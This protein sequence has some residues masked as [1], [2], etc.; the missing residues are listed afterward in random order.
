[1]QLAC[2][3]TSARG[4]CYVFLPA[5]AP[6]SSQAH[7]TLSRTLCPEEKHPYKAAVSLGWARSHTSATS[8]AALHAT[9]SP[10]GSDGTLLWEGGN[11]E[12]GSWR[13]TH[14]MW[15]VPACEGETKAGRVFESSSLQVF[16]Y[17]KRW[18]VAGIEAEAR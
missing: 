16:F 12:S 4:A 17:G 18:A 5:R 14:E 15:W 6:K 3:G 11:V 2:K 1:V 13:C 10:L 7:A 8:R 9:A